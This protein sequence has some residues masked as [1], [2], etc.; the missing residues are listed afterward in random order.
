MSGKK[1]R[2]SADGGVLDVNNA[3]R[4]ALSYQ[5]AD[6]IFT[7]GRLNSFIKVSRFILLVCI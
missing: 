5:P 3:M 1:R 6:E 2:G 4:K 7:N